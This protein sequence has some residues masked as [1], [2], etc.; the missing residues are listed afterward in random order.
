MIDLSELK[1]KF[2]AIKNKLSYQDKVQN[3]STLEKESQNA[4]LWHNPTKA[5]ELLQS[6]SFL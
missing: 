4:N 3:L 5:Q 2:E 1:S 6:I